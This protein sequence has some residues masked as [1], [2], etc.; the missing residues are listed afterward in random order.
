MRWLPGPADELASAP[1]WTRSVPA[2]VMSSST[3]R[4][5]LPGVTASGVTVPS[6]CVSVARS[7]AVAFV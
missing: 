5:P 7:G 3:Y 1:S 2:A 4:P 6:I